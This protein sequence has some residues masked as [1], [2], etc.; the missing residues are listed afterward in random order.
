MLVKLSGIP[1][2]REQERMQHPSQQEEKQ[3]RPPPSRWD[4]LVKA[5]LSTLQGLATRSLEGSADLVQAV[6][7]E[8]RS[9]DLETNGQVGVACQACRN[10][11][12]T[13]ASKV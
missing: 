13:K 6:I 9:H 11:H 2:T 4:P 12:A 5:V 3:K 10:A 7:L 1:I 8:R